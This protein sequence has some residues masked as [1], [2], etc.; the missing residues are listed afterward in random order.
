VDAN[1]GITDGPE[2]YRQGQALEQ[3]EVDMNIEALGLEVGKA[4][5]NGLESGADGMQ[6]IE[7]FF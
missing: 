2:V 4:V 3:W 5:G 6:M 7:A 1:S